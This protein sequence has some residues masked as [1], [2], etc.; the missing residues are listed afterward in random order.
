MGT[1]EVVMD[2]GTVLF[3]KRATGAPPTPST[4]VADILAH[5][6]ST[7]APTPPLPSPN[8]TPNPSSRRPFNSRSALVLLAPA[9]LAVAL[10]GWMMRRRRVE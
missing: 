6:R 1:F 5:I 8:P 9:V 7:T 4:V 2:D 10:A 3:S